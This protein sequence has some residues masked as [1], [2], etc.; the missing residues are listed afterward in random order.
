MCNNSPAPKKIDYSRKKRT[1]EEYRKWIAEKQLRRYH[2]QTPEQHEK[3]LNRMRAYRKTETGAQR[4]KLY[5]TTDYK[6]AQ[7]AERKYGTPNPYKIRIYT[8]YTT[9]KLAKNNIK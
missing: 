4:K 2:Q 3:W 7:L 5:N 6:I 9:R 8:K 1:P